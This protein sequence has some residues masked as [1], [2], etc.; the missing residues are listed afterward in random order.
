M[1]NSEQNKSG[2]EEDWRKA[3]DNAELVPDN[4]VWGGIEGHL[5]E[6][7]RRKNR[8]IFA[9]YSIAASVMLCLTC[10]MGWWIHSNTTA[11]QVAV[12]K[13]GN[14]PGQPT[15]GTTGTATSSSPTTRPTL[16]TENELGLPGSASA[17]HTGNGNH[18]DAEKDNAADV[19]HERMT[20]KGKNSATEGVTDETHSSSIALDK[21]STADQRG[22]NPLHSGNTPGKNLVAN[23]NSDPAKSFPYSSP[24]L[25]NRSINRTRQPSERR[26]STSETNGERDD[27][28]NPT[29]T[30]STGEED[31]DSKNNATLAAFTPELLSGK[32]VVVLSVASVS[33]SRLRAQTPV[34]LMFA[35]PVPEEAQVKKSPVWVS[36]SF[37]PNYFSSNV[38]TLYQPANNLAM[39]GVFVSSRSLSNVQQQEDKNQSNFSYALGIN[40]GKDLTKR[41]SI[42]GG[43]QYLYNSASLQTHA[44]VLN[45][46][47]NEKYPIISDLLSGTT[48]TVESPVYQANAVND[49]G[50]SADFTMA[51]QL[52]PTSTP[53]DLRNQYQYISFPVKLGYQLN[54]QEK[55][56]F[57]A[58]AGLSTDVFLKNTIDGNQPNIYAAE[59]TSG[60]E[61]A[62]RSVNVSGLVG[63]GIQYR[64][65]QR[66]SLMLE[67]T[68]RTA[69]FSTTKTTSNVRTMPSNMGIGLGMKFHF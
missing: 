37:M 5:Q 38:E 13:N 62:Y 21:T 68:Y 39:N 2:F 35:K 61:S 69:L 3:F 66:L 24:R 55:L 26:T 9:Y 49:K 44:Y 33:D 16:A 1:S 60:K 54:R 34:E 23:K 4:R 67:P 58:S 59:I 14:N 18:P 52:N 10:G 25:A 40:A 17:E 63:L 7:N 57:I 20:E 41:L 50:S 64:Y 15:S 48:N 56:R 47:T 43:V 32:E 6:Q 22:K 45:T 42:E 31:G 19:S 12:V 8:R 30:S 46:A 51:T 28:G 29:V 11:N 36:S 27:S 65:T 53:I